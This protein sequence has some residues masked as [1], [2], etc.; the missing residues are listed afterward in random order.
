MQDTIFFSFS[1]IMASFFLVLALTGVI[2]NILIK[3]AVMDVPNARSSHQTPVP[4]GGGWALLIVLLPALVGAALSIDSDV[5]HAGLIIA[6]FLLAAVSGIDDRKPV[7]P[8]MRLSF[9]ILAACLGAFSF[10]PT[11]LLLGGAVPFWLDRTLMILGWAWFINLYN[12]MDGIDGITGV[13]TISV[14]TGLCIVTAALG[15]SDPFV[16]FITL[17]LTGVCL[18]FLAH[19]WYP[20]KIFLGD[21]GSIPLGY[22]TGF[23]LLSLIVKGHWGAA[24]I[25]PLYYLADSSITL[26]RRAWRREKIWQAHREHFYQKAALVVG[27]HSKVV[28]FVI[29][30]NIGLIAAATLSVSR[31]WAGLG[32]GILIVAI[33]L[34]KMHRM[35]SLKKTAKQDR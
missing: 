7:N 9:H 33:L 15:I 28:T 30:A 10:A 31:P 35:G 6:L 2:R 23:C 12:F 1:L 19:N 22:L 29:I 20:A 16:S 25:L 13:E 11:D 21:V 3:R 24:L 18:G 17:I 27:A 34:G 32:V 26:A 4:R 8:A 5:R 14:A